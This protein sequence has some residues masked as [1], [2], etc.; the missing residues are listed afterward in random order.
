MRFGRKNDKTVATKAFLLLIKYD[1]YKR[2]SLAIWKFAV[3]SITQ[4][5]I[6][7]SSLS[8][9]C[10]KGLFEFDLETQVIVKHRRHNNT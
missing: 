3:I 10:L 1:L 9:E 2:I 8:I 7:Y 5:K 6:I 4:F